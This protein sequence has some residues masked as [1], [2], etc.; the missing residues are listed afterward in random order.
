MT[1]RTY[2][3][4]AGLALKGKRIAMSEWFGYG[5]PTAPDVSAVFRD[6]ARC[7]TDLGAT[8]ETVDP[9]LRLRPL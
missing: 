7:F 3:K 2:S 5:T 4:A 6:A 9:V 1:A 8:V